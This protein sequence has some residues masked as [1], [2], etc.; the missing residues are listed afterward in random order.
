MRIAAVL[1]IAAALD[2]SVSILPASITP[3]SITPAAVADSAIGT[4]AAA[5]PLASPSR[6]SRGAILAD[7][8]SGPAIDDNPNRADHAD[9]NDIAPNSAKPSSDLS[10]VERVFASFGMFGTW[11]ADCG[12]PPT[13]DN[14]RVTV[15]APGGG[16]VLEVTDLGP[17]YATNR[18]SALSARRLSPDRL[19]VNV[20][21][22]PGAPGE[23]RQT[24][25]FL[26]RN[27]TRRTL[28]NRVQGG[29]IRVRD[30]VMLARGVKTPVL[31][32]CG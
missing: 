23:E 16:V 30:G 22:R 7:A 12:R 31:K 21:F 13:P 29:D 25:I 26:V 32:K 20:I 14:P 2:L 8:V 15:T 17:G 19:E 18:Y 10:P 4:V 6:L 24:L 5:L 1:V 11:A 3:A 28:F 27:G 9:R